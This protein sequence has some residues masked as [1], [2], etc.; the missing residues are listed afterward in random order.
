MFLL[1]VAYN[2]YMKRF[3]VL[4]ISDEVTAC[5]CCGKT[6]LKRTV[7]MTEDGDNVLFFGCT[8]AAN[9]LNAQ[10]GYVYCDGR[11]VAGWASKKSRTSQD[12]VKSKAG[13]R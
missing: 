4:G 12:F 1:K 11:E 2:E 5:D 3:V 6:G 9:K 13:A 7:A 10:R 8:C